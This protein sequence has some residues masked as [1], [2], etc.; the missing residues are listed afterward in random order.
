VD[1]LAPKFFEAS[2]PSTISAIE[3]IFKRIFLGIFLRVTFS[4][5]EILIRRDHHYD[6]FPETT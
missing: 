4:R 1:G 2:V 3:I 6:L 5:V